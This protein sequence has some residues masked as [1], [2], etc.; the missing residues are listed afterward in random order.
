MT[1]RVQY[2]CE[3]CHVGEVIPLTVFSFDPKTAKFTE[4]EAMPDVMLCIECAQTQADAEIEGAEATGAVGS[5]KTG[6][7]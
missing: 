4:V 5:F 6:G 7:R 3:Q 2:F 1:K